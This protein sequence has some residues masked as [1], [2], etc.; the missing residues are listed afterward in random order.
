MLSSQY[1]QQLKS[2]AKN[3]SYGSMSNLHQT[4]RIAGEQFTKVKPSN[5]NK[6]INIHGTELDKAAVS[7][8][9]DIMK[10]VDISILRE[11]DKRASSS[12][13]PKEGR[14]TKRV[15]DDTIK[16][17]YDPANMT[18]AERNIL[19]AHTEKLRKAG[20]NDTQISKMSQARNLEAVR[21]IEDENF[22]AGK[23]RQLLPEDHIKLKRLVNVPQYK[24]SME[25]NTA[26]RIRNLQ[27]QGRLAPGELPFQ[28]GDEVTARRAGGLNSYQKRFNGINDD[29]KL[30]QFYNDVQNN[31][32]TPRQLQE[33]EKVSGVNVTARNGLGQR[34]FQQTHLDALKTEASG[35]RSAYDEARVIRNGIS[36]RSIRYTNPQQGAVAE[37]FPLVNRVLQMENAKKLFADLGNYDMNKLM[38]AKTANRMSRLINQN[39]GALKNFTVDITDP[40][41]EKAIGTNKV[42]LVEA[43]N[44]PQFQ[45]YQRGG[46]NALSTMDASDAKIALR[47]DAAL[48]TISGDRQLL[49]QVTD[50]MST[51][52]ARFAGL[53]RMSEFASSLKNT[54]ILSGAAKAGGFALQAIDPIIVGSQV[55]EIAKEK[56]MSTPASV[57]MAGGAAAAVG[58][59]IYGTYKNFLGKAFTN[60]AVTPATASAAQTVAAKEAAKVALQGSLMKA[61]GLG[62]ALTALT[63]GLEIYKSS[64]A[65]DSAIKKDKTKYDSDLE[66]SSGLTDTQRKRFSKI[67]NE[68][69]D[70]ERSSQGM[71]SLANYGA[72][73]TGLIVGGSLLA[74]LATGGIGTMAGLAL[75][76][77]GATWAGTS[78]FGGSGKTS[79]NTK[80]MQNTIKGV[81]NS[82]SFYENKITDYD[83]TISTLEYAKQS[84]G[85][86]TAAEYSKLGDTKVQR[87]LALTNKNSQLS[88]VNTLGDIYDNKQIQETP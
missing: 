33:F 38:G 54:P 67:N 61:V 41:M 62:G 51:G 32:F 10:D 59:G 37:R 60:L 13:S 55:Y 36:D 75:A 72:L 45:Q 57:T 29:M 1:R 81:T 18:N 19:N 42:N 82:V 46:I 66:M 83:K 12:G 69:T 65:S 73:K 9:Q 70:T 25:Q 77:G 86:L 11:H 76:G 63:T 40:S 88:Q 22:L 47:G 43:V 7:L 80:E 34:I 20:F 35:A 71:K 4:D 49:N 48:R 52:G 84:G 26:D 16:R 30:S 58:G 87:Q 50:V 3:H 64:V 28:A 56:G 79:E 2:A 74:G 39:E 27:Q 23:G 31:K 78:Y 5:L 14:S 85:G 24:Y 15:V 6:M 44:T 21:M 68:V 53:S 8:R 17:A